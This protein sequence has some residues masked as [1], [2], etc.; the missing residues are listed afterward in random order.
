MFP[1]SCISILTFR[2][3]WQVQSSSYTLELT[4]TLGANNWLYSMF[5]ILK[6]HSSILKGKK[7]LVKTIFFLCWSDQHFLNISD[8]YV[9][10]CNIYPCAAAQ[11]T[12]G[13]T[14][15]FLDCGVGLHPM[16]LVPAAGPRWLSLLLRF[17]TGII[18]PGNFLCMANTQAGVWFPVDL[19]LLLKD[20]SWKEVRAFEGSVHFHVSL[21]SSLMF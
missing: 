8:P 5:N 21:A 3:S 6:I 16:A 9:C 11:A 18:K 1:E 10:S 17:H 7:N 13:S 12:K 20:F 19:H 4:P 14:I 15:T 2:S